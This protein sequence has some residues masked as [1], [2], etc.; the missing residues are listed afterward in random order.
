[1]SSDRDASMA[2]DPDSVGGSLQDEDAGGLF[3]SGSEDEG[4]MYGLSTKRT[5]IQY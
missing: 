1:M 5:F 4:S 3:G 2:S